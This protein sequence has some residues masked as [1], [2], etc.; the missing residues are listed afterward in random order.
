MDKL[1]KF[2]RRIKPDF[3]APGPHVTIDKLDA[4]LQFVQQ[5]EKNSHDPVAS[6]DPDQRKIGYYESKNV[7]G[8]L[9]RMIDE[10]GFYEQL[11]TLSNVSPDEK[12]SSVM[13]QVL[14]YVL[15]ASEGIVFSHY[16]D[17]AGKIRSDYEA[18]LD[19]ISHDYALHPGHPLHEV[20]VVGGCALGSVFNRR[21]KDSI[22]AMRQQYARDVAHTRAAIRTDD[23]GTTDEA[24]PRSIA[25]L[26]ITVHHPGLKKTWSGREVELKSFAYVAAAV[27]MKELEIFHGGYLRRYDVKS[28]GNV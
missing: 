9:Y 18:S 16:L 28:K 13:E 3:M 20:E 25:C 15:A 2:N 17:L 8:Q 27:C 10:K 23:H 11:R 4:G 22:H 24:L 12:P 5:E 19:F 26:Y 1:P 6:L 7:L 14:D 21:L